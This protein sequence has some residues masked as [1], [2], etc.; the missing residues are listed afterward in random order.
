MKKVVFLLV[1][2]LAVTGAMFAQSLE[3]A[4]AAIPAAS[5]TKSDDK[6]TWTFA[7]TSLTIRDSGGSITIP[8]RDLKD[9]AA[10]SGAAGVTFGY[11]TAA[12][13]R[14]YRI[15]LNPMTGELRL[16]ITRDGVALPEA[17]LTKN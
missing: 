11:D 6:A 4:W 7:A 17:I 16:A 10:A 1:I 3:G 8:I 12:Y 14:T 5:Y 13:K 15:T 2:L 9:L